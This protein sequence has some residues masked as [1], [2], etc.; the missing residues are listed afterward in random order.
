[1]RSTL[2]LLV[3]LTLFTLAGCGGGD[4]TPAAPLEV[5]TPTGDGIVKKVEGVLA[6]QAAAAEGQGSVKF[7]VFHTDRLVND[8]VTIELRDGAG[9]LARKLAG[10][11]TAEVPAGPYTAALTYDE[12]E[13]LQGYKG[14]LAALVVHPGQLTTYKVGI[15]AP[16]GILK[17]KFTDGTENLSDK[18]KLTIFRSV[19]D[20]ELVVGP[21]WEGMAGDS[22]MLPVDSYQVRAVY[23]PDKGAPITEWHRDISVEPALARTE[24]DIVLELDLTGLRVDAFNFGKDVNA[25]TRVYVYAEGAD[26]QFAVAKF[27]G[28]AGEAVPAD[29]GLY[30]VRVVYMPS[31]SALKFVGDKT[32]KSV[33]V[34]AGLGTRVQL[35]LGLPQAMLKL[36]VTEGETDLSDK[37]EIRVMRTGADREA[38]SPLVDE[39][40]VG[41]HPIP[42]GVAD[43]Y[44]R[45]LNTAGE[46]KAQTFKAVELQNGWTWEQSFDVSEPTWEARPPLKPA[47]PPRPI[48]FVGP[49]DDDDSAGDDDDSAGDDDDSGKTAAPPA[50]APKAPAPK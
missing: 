46:V 49:G 21:V 13:R 14:S 18:V 40:G 3:G 17:M 39:L 34:N 26:V 25:S 43:I 28:R 38:A 20:P 36:K 27:Q 8:K 15:E 24:R 45:V 19:D 32:L 31:S 5:G 4:K 29:P 42:V 11:E 44:L 50:P 41:R 7:D 12:N 33:K 9:N 1:M 48:E 10:N 37:T 35:D 6:P 30:D 2:L 23:A 16:I 47:A 22:V